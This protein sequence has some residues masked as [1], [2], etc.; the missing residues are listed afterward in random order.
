MDLSGVPLSERDLFEK[1]E[2]MIRRLLDR[3]L[4][5]MELKADLPKTDRKGRGKL[6]KKKAT[7]KI[8]HSS[9]I[10]IDKLKNELRDIK[11]TTYPALVAQREAELDKIKAEIRLL[12]GHL[13]KGRPEITARRVRS[14]SS[15]LSQGTSFLSES[16]AATTTT[17][18]FSKPIETMDWFADDGVS[19]GIF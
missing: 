4:E 16:R 1:N 2:E 7:Q 11:S 15:S 18:S 19:F 17:S 12:E 10:T 8:D 3:Q 6:Q 14:T 5:L 9:Q 13:I